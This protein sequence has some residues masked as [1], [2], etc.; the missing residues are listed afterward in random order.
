MALKGPD[1]CHGG[2]VPCLALPVSAHSHSAGF[3]PS[4]HNTHMC[5]FL[6]E[7]LILARRLKRKSLCKASAL[8]LSLITQLI[9]YVAL[10][11]K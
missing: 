11:T 4:S 3:G 2:W 1:V 9:Y 8:N 10:V 6:E 7:M 5:V